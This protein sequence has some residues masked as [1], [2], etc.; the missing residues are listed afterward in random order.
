MM[1]SKTWIQYFNIYFVFIYLK[2]ELENEV[3]FVT[4][5]LRTDKVARK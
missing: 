5:E 1:K 4:D 2:F 3:F